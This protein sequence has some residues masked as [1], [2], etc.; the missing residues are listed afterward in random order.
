MLTWSYRQTLAFDVEPNHSR[1]S[2]NPSTS[3]IRNFKSDNILNHYEFRTKRVKLDHISI[4]WLLVLNLDDNRMSLQHMILPS[5]T[6]NMNIEW[7]HWFNL[8]YIITIAGFVTWV[9][10]RRQ[11]ML[12]LPEHQSAPMV[13]VA[14]SSGFCVVWTLTFN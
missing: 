1:H 14:Y 5:R 10:L 13:L 7:R 3:H 2:N 12:T 9:T 4:S 6:L 11:E 8:L